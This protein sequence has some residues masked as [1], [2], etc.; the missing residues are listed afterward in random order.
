MYRHALKTLER[1]YGEF[2]APA[3]QITGR[4][5]IGERLKRFFGRWEDGRT[6]AYADYAANNRLALHR[7]YAEGASLATPEQRDRARRE[8]QHY[9]DEIA[10]LVPQRAAS[11]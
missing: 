8:L 5:G 10:A 11:R 4:E 3:R 2:D 9:I 6:L 7:F 1:W